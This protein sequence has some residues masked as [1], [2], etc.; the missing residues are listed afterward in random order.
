MQ[1]T[2]RELDDE[3]NTEQ[4]LD[5]VSE[6][7]ESERLLIARQIL[8]SLTD[9]SPADVL[10]ANGFLAELDRRSNDWDGAVSWEELKAQLL[11]EN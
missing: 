6:L 3:L 8:K 10:D 1:I 9:P 11:D 4:I 7:P 2:R 5:A